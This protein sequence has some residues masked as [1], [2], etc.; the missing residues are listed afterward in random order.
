MHLNVTQNQS[1][2]MELR[3]ELGMKPGCTVGG[4]DDEME[5]IWR[6]KQGRTLKDTSL[7]VN[8]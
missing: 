1:P 6:E 3:H 2:L 5:E 7:L 8:V 4:Q